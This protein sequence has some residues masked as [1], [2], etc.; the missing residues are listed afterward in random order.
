MKHP[1][2]RR[3]RD[4]AMINKLKQGL[5]HVIDLTHFEIDDKALEGKG[6]LV[7]D[8]RN[9]R[10]F[11]ALSPRSHEDVVNEFINKWN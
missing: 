7:A 9:R 2:R 1:S 8:H 5:R 3:E 4:R 10:F 11:C 6:S